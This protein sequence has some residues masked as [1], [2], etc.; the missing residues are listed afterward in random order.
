M[1]SESPS[2]GST[3]EPCRA[4]AGSS[5]ASAAGV[6]PSSSIG[7]RLSMSVI[8]SQSNGGETVGG[9]APQPCVRYSRCASRATCA[10]VVPQRWEGAPVHTL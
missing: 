6:V 3:S 5:G 10:Q 2:N 1:P 7:T 4:A 9:N 8:E